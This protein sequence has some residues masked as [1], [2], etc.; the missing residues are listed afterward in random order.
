[1]EKYSESYFLK[2]SEAHETLHYIYWY[3][4]LRKVNKWEDLRSCSLFYL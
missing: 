1:M 2:K 3:H 4:C